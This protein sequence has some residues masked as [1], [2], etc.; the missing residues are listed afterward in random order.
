MYFLNCRNY[1]KKEQIPSVVP[2]RKIPV[3]MKFIVEENDRIYNPPCKTSP[4]KNG[5]KILSAS[6]IFPRTQ[7]RR[8]E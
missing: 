3:S 4:M 2:L 1:L 8:H 7:G 5:N 6:S